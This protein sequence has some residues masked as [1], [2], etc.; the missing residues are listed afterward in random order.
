[1]K[2]QEEEGEEEEGREEEAAEP[3]AGVKSCQCMEGEMAEGGARA[4]LYLL[5]ATQQCQ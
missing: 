1:M 2:K 4:Y 3:R 5:R